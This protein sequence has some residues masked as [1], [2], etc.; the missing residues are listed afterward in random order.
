VATTE[1]RRRH[2]SACERSLEWLERQSGRSESD[3]AV[4]TH[5]ALG[6]YCPIGRPSLSRRSFVVIKE[7]TKSMAT[8]NTPTG[9][10]LRVAVDE[11]IAQPLM[12]SLVMIMGHELGQGAAE[13]TLP[14]R[15][16]PIQAL[17]FDRSHKA[18]R[19]RVRVRRV[20]RRAHRADSGPRRIVSGVT[21]V[22]T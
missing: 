11:H 18:L 21:I 12:I 2:V 3:V 14:D 16:D 6:P 13:V 8:A 5:Q 15:D 9:L 10:P 20:Y 4:W 19:M 17:F 22:A 7:P 1:L